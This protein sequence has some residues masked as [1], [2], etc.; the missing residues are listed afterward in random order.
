[1]GAQSVGLVNE[2]G[3]LGPIK[4]SMGGHEITLLIRGG[5]GGSS[6]VEWG[7]KSF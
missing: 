3:H 2:G 7:R 5:L 6:D 1:M 4:R